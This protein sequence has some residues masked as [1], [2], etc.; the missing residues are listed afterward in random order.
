MS[1]WRAVNMELGEVSSILALE[2]LTLEYLPRHTLIFLGFK[3]ADSHPKERQP[4]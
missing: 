1:S 3:G 4:L 2:E